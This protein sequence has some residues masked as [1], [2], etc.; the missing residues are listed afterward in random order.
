LPRQYAKNVG[1]NLSVKFKDGNKT[2]GKLA[3]VQE[4]HILLQE[5]KKEKG[6]KAQTV[7]R[8]IPLNEITESKVLISF[9]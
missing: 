9:K 2:E 1:R 8:L 7:D 3:E 4:G 6:K 5:V